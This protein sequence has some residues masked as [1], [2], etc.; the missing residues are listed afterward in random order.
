[1]KICFLAGAN[2]I[3]SIRWI[4]YF[5]KAGEK[6]TWIS[7]APP[8]NEA[9]DFIGQT[10]FLNLR[11]GKN[12]LSLVNLPL[13][14]WKIHKTIRREK[15]EIVHAHYAGLYGLIGALLNFHPFVL[16]VWGSDVLIFPSNFIKKKITGF[17]LKKADLITVD[18]YNCRDAILKFSVHPKKV[19]FIQFGVDAE[20]FR[21]QGEPRPNTVLSLRSL[22]PIY[23]I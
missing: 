13:N 17:I 21:P 3:H 18:G 9:R 19:N 5:V 23:N 12:L 16:T 14:L 2:T 10:N 7:F 15:I 1:M 11:L 6:I 8:L 4:R 22:E 20:K